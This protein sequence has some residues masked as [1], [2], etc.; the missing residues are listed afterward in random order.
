[1][2]FKSDAAV[3]LILSLLIKGILVEFPNTVYYKFKEKH[4]VKLGL[5]FDNAKGMVLGEQRLW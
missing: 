1:M 4:L 3:P 2:T 5:L